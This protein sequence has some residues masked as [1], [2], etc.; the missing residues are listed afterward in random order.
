MLMTYALRA[1][2]GRHGTFLVVFLFLTGAAQ[3]ATTLYL[4]R[5]FEPSE[6]G[7]VG[8]AIMNPK[9]TPSSLTFRLR[10]AAGDAAFTNTRSIPSKGQLS[11]TLGQLFPDATGPGW[12]SV[13]S[14]VDQVSGFW[15]T[16]D[17]VSSTDG[18]PLLSSSEA[19]AYPAFAYFSSASEISFVNLGSSAVTGNLNLISAS[20]TGVASRTFSLPPLGLYQNSVASLFPAH[21]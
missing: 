17:F 5:Q 8:V 14:S 1:L 20:G 7:T 21:A 2:K 18:A 3:A 11:L 13:D 6:M 9:S 10:T 16:G 19:I 4:P 15:M 12:M